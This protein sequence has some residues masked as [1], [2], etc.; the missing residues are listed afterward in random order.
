MTLLFRWRQTDFYFLLGEEVGVSG[1]EAVG[2]LQE[3]PR[4]L[5]PARRLVRRGGTEIPSPVRL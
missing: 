4:G 1:G 5:V 3:T 2:W